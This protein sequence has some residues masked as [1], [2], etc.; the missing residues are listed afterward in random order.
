LC[1]C[2]LQHLIPPHIVKRDKRALALTPEVLNLLWVALAQA[3]QAG[4][5]VVAGSSG[6]VDEIEAVNFLDDGAEEDSAGRVA[7]PRV[8][9]A[10]G[11]VGPQRVVAKVVSGRLGLFRKR[12]HVRRGG[13]IPVLVGPELARGADAGLD[14]VDNEHDV[15]L[16]CD[17]A[18]SAEKVWCCVVVAAFGLDGLDDDG[19]GWVVELLDEALGFVQAPFLLCRILGFVLVEGILEGGERGLWP[20]EGGDVELVDGFGACRGQTAKEAAVKPGLERENGHVGGARRFVVHGRGD[21]FGGEFGVGTT[22]LLLA[23]PHEGGFVGKFV[24]VGT[25]LGGE[26]LIKT[27]G[28]YRQ[29]ASLEDVR[30]VVL[31]E[32]AESGAVD[33]GRCHLRRCSCKKER[34]IVVAH[35][36]R[37]NLRVNIEKHIAVKIRN[38]VNR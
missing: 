3:L 11:L 22:T 36:N 38:T 29:D 28:G 13:E 21:V 17:F 4:V 25:G 15:V 27:F 32:V 31:G 6:A 26:D 34:R 5:E 30:P 20:V 18:E 24:G 1:L 2:L 37:S 23:L 33:D 7:H 35:G 14:F 10:V 12:D 19:G 9:L 8:E 16:L